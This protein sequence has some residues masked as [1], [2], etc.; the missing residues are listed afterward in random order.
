MKMVKHVLCVGVILALSAGMAVSG[1]AEKTK[2][3]MMFDAVQQNNDE[4]YREFAEKY[5]ETHPDIDI[6]VQYGPREV[7]DLLGLFL[8]FFEVKSPEVDIYGI[9]IIW[10]GELAEHLVDL[11]EYG[12]RDHTQDHFQAIIENN[13]VDGKLIAIPYMTNAPVMF[14]RTDLLGKYGYAAPPKTWD[15]L[16]EMAAKIQEGER[17]DGNQDFWGFVFQGKAYEGLTCDALEWV[18]SSGGGTVVEADKTVSINNP[19]AVAAIQRAG[20]WVGTIAPAGV[21]GFAEEDSRAVFQAGNAAFHRNWPYV[22]S[23]ANKDD[24]AIKGK[25]DMTLI[26]GGEEGQTAATLGGL[27]LAVSKYSEHPKEAAEVALYF[28]GRDFQKAQLIRTTTP[29]SIIDLYDDPDVL[30]VLPFA[31]TLKNVLLQAV[32]RPSTASAPH[33][34][35]LSRFFFNAVYDVL[36]HKKDADIALEELEIDLQDLLE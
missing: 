2:V 21:A 7:T 22:W 13:T 23:L 20:D 34:S 35:D 10:A 18:A 32:A 31:A 9:D 27:Q 14:Y 19:K 3:T 1:W 8:Q 28:A 36:T 17:A 33:Y 4:L 15:E 16:T 6:V 29:P 12:A 5:M 30:D 11:Y 24:S 25:F 26:P